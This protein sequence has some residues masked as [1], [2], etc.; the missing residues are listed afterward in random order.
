MVLRLGMPVIR[1]VFAAKN[2]K[3]PEL[4]RLPPS[5]VSLVNTTLQVKIGYFDVD[6][7]SHWRAVLA[8][9]VKGA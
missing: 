4:T 6:L 5:V 2:K 1:G 7:L 9:V 3:C 8:G